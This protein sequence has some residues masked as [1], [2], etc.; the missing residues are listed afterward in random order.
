MSTHRLH[1]LLSPRSVALVGASPR[2]HS[3]GRQILKNLRVAGFEGAV[4]LVN[5]KYLEIEGIAAIK[6]VTTL[7]P[8]DLLIIAAPPPTVP[9][10]VATAAAK[11][12]GAA[13][14]ITAGLGHGPDS[15]AQACEL[16]AREHGMRL[17]GPNC[18]G[19][20]IP[21]A[22]LDASFAAH[23]ARPGD[24]ALIS[25]S[26]AIAAGLIE[27]AAR[28]SVGFSGVVSIG[29]QIDVD[30]G[31]LLDHFATDSATRAIVK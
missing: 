31:D 16:A 22:K 9:E 15:L 5:P 24:I 14:I 13:I 28:R 26:G 6:D 25:Q 18:L 2:E 7:P 21:R 10:I 20:Q 11:G 19:I 27:W 17:L 4:R 30:F 1:C 29:N 12:I 8:T 23:M 3:V